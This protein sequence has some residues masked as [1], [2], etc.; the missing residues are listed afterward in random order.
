MHYLCPLF[1]C[2][3]ACNYCQK[4]TRT[5]ELSPLFRSNNFPMI[6]HPQPKELM[7]QEYNTIQ[8]VSHKYYVS[9]KPL[10]TSE[11]TLLLVL[12]QVAMQ[13]LLHTSIKVYLSAVH[14]L[15]VTSR[16]HHHF[17]FDSSPSNSSQWYQK[18]TGYNQD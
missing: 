16:N 9:Y 8:I 4:L 14:N 17:A 10:R 13:Q 2:M 7:P 18:R 12:A 1:V 6:E 11:H 5:Y 3:H 15:H